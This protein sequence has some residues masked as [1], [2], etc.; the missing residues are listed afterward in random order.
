MRVSC[1]P[2]HPDSQAIEALCTA[3]AAGEMVRLAILLKAHSGWIDV[4]DA[5]SEPRAPLHHAAAAG[6]TDAVAGLLSVGAN[7]NLRSGVLVVDGD[8][9]QDW[10]WEPGRT[11]LTFAAR[12]GHADVVHR[13]LDAGADAAACDRNDF[14]VLHAAAVGGS[15][16]IIRTLV[17]RKVSLNGYSYARHFDEQLGWAFA[18]TPLHAA[19]ACGNDAATAA[20]IE[21]GARL[22]ECWIDKRTPIFYAAAYGRAGTIRALARAAANVNAV[23]DRAEH[24]FRVTMTPLHYAARNGHEEAVRALLDAGA[25]PTARDQHS[26]Q[27]PGEMACENRHARVAAMILER[28][29]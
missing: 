11:P 4:R 2:A 24:S 14:S 23:E 7:P 25:D 3:A 9:M 26:K 10:Y 17:A 15:E 18:G 29:K 21:A 8:S 16:L 28:R 6:Q 13:L 1:S 27:T 19:A 5:S 22:E 20:L 12:G